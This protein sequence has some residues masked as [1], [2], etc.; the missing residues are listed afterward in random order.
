MD[1]RS[2]DPNACWVRH[3]VRGEESQPSAIKVGD[4][5]FVRDGAAAGDDGLNGRQ[6]WQQ[7]ETTTVLSDDGS[8]T[9]VL[10]NV[11]G[12]DG[13]LHR[14][15]FR[16]LTDPEY[17]PGEEWLEFWRD[18]ND[19]VFIGTPTEYT[20]TKSIITIKGVDLNVVLAGVLSGD[21]DVW[22][23]TA[24]A[25][26]L[27]HYTRLPI[28]AY[29]ADL[30]VTKTGGIGAWSITPYSQAL[31]GVSTDCWTCEV[32]AR[33]TSARPTATGAS[34]VRMDVAGLTLKVDMFDGSTI[35]EGAPER[36]VTGKLTGLVVPGPVD[37]R[38]VARYDRIFAFVAGELVAEF[39]RTERPVATIVEANAYGG[40]I[41]IDGAQVETLVSFAT[42]GSSAVIDRHLPGTPPET[43][44]R[45]QYWNAAPVYA[46]YSTREG[47]L[48]RLYPLLGESEPNVERVD[49]QVNFP[50]G[51]AGYPPNLPGAY[52]VRWTG[53][54]YLD[55]GATDRKIRLSGLVGNA[56]IYVGRTFRGESA[57]SSW[58]SAAGTTPITTAALRT[59]IGETVAGWYPIMIEQ[60]HEAAAAGIVLEDSPVD[61]EGKTTGEGYKTVPQTR[62]SP[63]GCYADTVRLTAHRQVIGDVTQ[64]FGYQW[65]IEHRGLETGE[66]PGQLSAKALIGQQTN[67]TISDEDLATE[68]QVTGSAL[69]VADGIIADA[70]GIADPKGSGQLSAQTVDYTRDHLALRQGYESLSDI[71]DPQLLETRIDSLLALRS[72]PN[73]QV[74]V[75]P[76]GQRDLVD[77]FPLT[78]KLAKMNWEPGDAP[79]LN[80]DSID[81]KDESPRQ[82]T[83]VSWQWRPDGIGAPTVGFRQRPRTPR[84]ALKRLHA[85]IFSPRRNYQGSFATTTGSAGGTTSAGAATNGAVD[86]YSRIPLPANIDQIDRI[87]AAVQIL[88]GTGWRLEVAGTDL[89]AS[90]GA[91][92]VVGRYDITRAA[93]QAS[94]GAPYTYARLI[95][96]ASGNYLLTLEV[97]VKI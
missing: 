74:G 55:L 89:G 5:W 67:V 49:P 41:A 97:T 81:V 43:G 32:R 96:G 75:R 86:S 2:I 72:S 22:D 54:I 3:I 24:P 88:S 77:T 83:T 47:R 11:A 35:L 34:F 61:A 65:R 28:L 90:D 25:D 12:D 82:L 21:V 4:V 64:T 16:I 94:T 20:K 1:T 18:P 48:A 53:A 57:A 58:G 19:E 51:T 31:S 14:R 10:P 23:G 36:A 73:E 79:M 46:Q 76:S 7:G 93:K 95:G 85:A 50:A 84:A 66:F 17:E 15:R 62:L 91:V 70:A 40:T 9:L 63:I 8:F 68:A 44:L 78:G 26:M 27:H 71:T 59:W 38:I 56:R 69:D 45:A 60:A 92:P 30:T 39:R 37:L 87:V 42:R 6:G 33:W 13:I 29:G 80:L 52:S